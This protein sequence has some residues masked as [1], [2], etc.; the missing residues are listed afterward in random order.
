[1]KNNSARLIYSSSESAD[2]FY[3][4]DFFAPDNFVYLE[5]NGKKFILMSDLEFGRAKKQCKDCTVLHLKEYKQKVTKAGKKMGLVNIIDAFLR[6]RRISEIKVPGNFPAWLYKKL[7]NKKYKVKCSRDDFFPERQVKSKEEQDAIGVVQRINEN[8]LELALKMLKGA[9]VRNNKLY[10]KGKPLTSEG[11]KRV[12]NHFYLDN[13]CICPE[14]II[15]SCDSQTALPHHMGSGVLR[16]NVPIIIDLFPRS[17]KSGYWA[18]MTRTVVK[19]KAEKKLKE[20]YDAVLA[21]QERGLSM[22]RDGVLASAVHNETLKVLESH[23]FPNKV[24]RGIPQGLIH[25]TGH[26]LGLEIHEKPRLGGENK[27]PLKAGNVV[28]I[29]P[30]LYYTGIGG[31]RIEDLVIVTKRG[32]RNLTK[33]KKFL[34]IL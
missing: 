21:S 3:A 14:G 16:A 30:G 22:I 31:V 8:A 9:K 34:E 7:V 5:H 27:E 6:E 29:E 4:V 23:G 32:C 18:D 13:D 12:L 1:M 19:G 26:G 15:I 17:T 24:V 11:I 33:P 25:T 28:T 10:L 2:M 20:M